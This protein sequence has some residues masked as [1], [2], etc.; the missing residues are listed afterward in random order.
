MHPS[1][2]APF[3]LRS[4]H[5]PAARAGKGAYG[6][7]CSAKDVETGDKVAVKKIQNAF[8]NLTDATRTL[9]EI[10]L[11]RHLHHENIIKV[12]RSLSAGRSCLDLEPHV[13]FQCREQVRDILMPPSR[14]AFNDVYII[15]ELMASRKTGT[16][17][18]RRTN[19]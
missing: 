14:E 10:K 16:R 3:D 1:V 7:V 2:G 13:S 4:F 8:E 19:S 11:L 9:R 12:R 17:A 15:Y 18:G 5:N 6:V